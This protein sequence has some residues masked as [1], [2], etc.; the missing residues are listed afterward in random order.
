MQADEPDNEDWGVNVCNSALW[1][2]LNDDREVAII[3]VDEFEK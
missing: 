3:L 1:E 2:R